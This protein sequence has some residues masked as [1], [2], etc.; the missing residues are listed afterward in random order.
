MADIVVVEAQKQTRPS[1]TR[2]FKLS[3]VE[4]YYNNNKNIFQATNKFRVDRK[5]MRNWIAGKENIR[6]QKSKSKNVRERKAQYHPLEKE[7]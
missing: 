1:F 7:L 2:E 3:V 5:Q 6:K 4:W